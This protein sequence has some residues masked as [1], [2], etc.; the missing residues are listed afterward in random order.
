MK[1][2]ITQLKSSTANFKSSVNQAEGKNQQM[3]F[4]IINLLKTKKANIQDL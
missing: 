3:L 4:K 2:T 1:N